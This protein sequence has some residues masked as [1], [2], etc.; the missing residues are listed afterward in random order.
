MDIQSIKN[1]FGI[2][3]NTP[4]LNHALHVAAQVANTDLSVLIVG[5]SGV[6]KEAFSQIIHALSARKHNPFI[7]V[8]CG[9]I[10]EGTIDSEL[11]G[12]EKGAFTGAVD[13]RK[14]YFE[15]VNGG[16]IFLDEIGEM[17]LG[18]Q[19]RLLR[20]LETGE[21]IRVGSSKVQKTDVRVIAATNRELLEFTQKGKFR[22]DLYYRLSTVPI[23]VPALRDRKEDIPLL[24][25]KFA[26]DFAERYKTP[27]VQLEEDAR[28]LLI[29]YSWPGNVRE[30]KNI[31]EQI[32]VLAGDKSISALEL[33]RFLPEQ[34]NNR[35]PMLIGNG[36]GSG[37]HEFNSERE[38]LYKLFF[39][40]KKDVTELK[41]MFVEILQNPGEAAAAAAYTKESLLRE[42]PSPVEYT[43]PATVLPSPATYVQPAAA[44]SVL[45]PHTHD[46]IHEHEEVEESLNIM[47]KEKELILK[48]LKKHKGKRK[49][50]AADLGISERTLYRKLKEY[51]INE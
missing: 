25:R 5:E 1:R 15:T 51:D 21:F 9:A 3:G 31:A 26:V 29:N 2:I 42:Y 17:P 27:P 38:I 11:F 19:A 35:L 30:L 20:V 41:K 10:P 45:M 37:G 13:S 48:A 8:N 24:F 47:D 46:E 6:G 7:A 28:Q 16:T 39:D 43:A 34:A 33:K 22:E 44:T 36:Q 4:S 32:S 49:D 50:A 12:H 18:T 23:R 40:M 14:G